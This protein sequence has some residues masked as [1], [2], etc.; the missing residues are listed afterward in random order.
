MQLPDTERGWGGTF[1]VCVEQKPRFRSERRC[2]M[3]F[4]QHVNRLLEY[5]IISYSITDKAQ[6]SRDVLLDSS[7]SSYSPISMFTCTEKAR[8]E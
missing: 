6:E 5:Q 8:R 7:K 2:F 4:S 3:S 1:Q